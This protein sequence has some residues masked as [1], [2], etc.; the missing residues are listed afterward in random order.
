M[1]HNTLCPVHRSFIAMSGSW[2]RGDTTATLAA[3]LA[4]AINAATGTPV[5]ATASGGVI[6]LVS[7]TAGAGTNYAVS[8]AI[9]DTQMASYPA[10]FSGPS[11]AA[12]AENMSGGAAADASYGTIYSYEAGYAPNGNIL[13]HNDSVMGNWYFTYDAMDRLATAAAGTGVNV[14]SAFRGQNAAWSYDS[15]GNRTA[16][17]FSSGSYSNWANY[18]STNN[19]ITTASTALGGYVYDASGN[20]LNDGNNRYW[21]DAEGQLCA[22]QSLATTGLPI[23]QYVYDAEGARIAKTT[24]SAAPANPV[25]RHNSIRAQKWLGF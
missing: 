6:S 1:S 10:L 2:D 9:A 7:N 13:T 12:G 25:T 3:K 19:H 23:T 4:T 15:F 16:Q 22:Q 21:Y 17:T 18:N 20:T 11:F 24:L 5:T 8:A 14:P